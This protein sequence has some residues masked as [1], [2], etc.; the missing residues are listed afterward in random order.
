MTSISP[1]PIT[2]QSEAGMSL[3]S[4]MLSI[5][6]ST[7]TML[8]ATHMHT[9]HQIAVNELN[10]SIKHDR[11]ILTSLK[12]IEKEILSAGYGISDADENDI[13]TIHT[14]ADLTG[15]TP[16]VRRLLWRYVFE[17]ATHC[18][19]LIE[20]GIYVNGVEFRT[21]TLRKAPDTAAT[22]AEACNTTNALSA[23]TYNDTIGRLGEWEVKDGMAAR[24][25]TNTTLFSFNLTNATCS[26][27]GLSNPA[28]HMSVTIEAPNSAELNGH[29][30]PKNNGITLCLTN[31]TPTTS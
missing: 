1:A 29:T 31:I 14:P 28:A 30:F 12:V 3:I 4:L 6:L 18:R 13:M 8:A 19:M 5:A 2:K 16:A 21:L 24:I 9:S 15:P 10:D 17:G 25:N 20:S 11:T 23:I 27:P 7:V 26:F 22:P